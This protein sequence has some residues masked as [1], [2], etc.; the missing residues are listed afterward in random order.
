MKTLVLAGLIA[1]SGLAS[2]QGGHASHAKQHGHAAATQDLRAQADQAKQS[3]SVQ[4][5]ECWI[6]SLPAPAP[7]AGYFLLKNGGDKDIKLQGA[8]SPTYGMVMLHQTM[9][10]DG[11]SKM[12]ETHDVVIPAGGE[13]AF[14]PGGYHAMLEQ[15]KTAPAIGSQVGIDLLFDNGE[16]ASAQCEVKPANTKAH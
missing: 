10:H 8:V 15:A 5:S 16:K 6:R 4:V 14:K 9:Q 3:E 12:S 7:S 11:M 1:F 13:L 2:A